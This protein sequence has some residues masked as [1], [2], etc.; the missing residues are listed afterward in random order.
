MS[1]RKEI[2]DSFTE[3][4]LEVIKRYIKL[5]REL[6][7]DTSGRNFGVRFNRKKNPDVIKILDDMDNRSSYIYNLIL[8]D[9]KSKG[10]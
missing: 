6:S 1:F 7:E 2:Y 8:A 3:E 10:L 5:Q 4:E 9:M